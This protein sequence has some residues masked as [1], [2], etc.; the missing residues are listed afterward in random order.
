MSISGRNF[1]VN[2]QFVHRGHVL[3]KKAHLV[4]RWAFC[5]HFKIDQQKAGPTYRNPPSKIRFS[6]FD[7]GGLQ[8]LT[9]SAGGVFE[10][11]VVDDVHDFVEVGLAF[12]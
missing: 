4:T 2:R 10:A 3:I 7:C 9:D 6:R 5:C 8:G 11:G 12:V 1:W